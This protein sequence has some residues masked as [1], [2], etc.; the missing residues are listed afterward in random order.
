[1]SFL[2]EAV[3]AGTAQCGAVPAGANAEALRRS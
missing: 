1:M 2:E 3:V